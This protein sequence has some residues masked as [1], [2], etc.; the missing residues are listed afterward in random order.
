[1]Q[2]SRVEKKIT[3][4]SNPIPQAGPALDTPL[5]IY[6]QFFISHSKYKEMIKKQLKK[7][8]DF[9]L[10]GVAYV[11]KYPKSVKNKKSSAK[12]QNFILAEIPSIYPI[13]LYNF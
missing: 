9:M 8:G 3:Y 10:K 5:K 12:I 4:T 2:E 13:L 7:V 11:N 1:M 6:D